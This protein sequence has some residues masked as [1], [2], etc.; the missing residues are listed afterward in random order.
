MGPGGEHPQI[1]GLSA[2]YISGFEA[3]KNH[4]PELP[5]PMIV[6]PVQQRPSYPD[7]SVAS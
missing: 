1:S 3:G 5:S 6:T 2:I 4:V 7:V